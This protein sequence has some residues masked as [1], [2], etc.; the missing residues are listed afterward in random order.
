MT[1]ATYKGKHLLCCLSPIEPHWEGAQWLGGT[2][3]EQ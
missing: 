2:A 3:L 1:T